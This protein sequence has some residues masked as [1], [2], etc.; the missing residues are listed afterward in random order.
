MVPQQT[1]RDKALAF[2]FRAYTHA[3]SRTDYLRR[4]A[5]GL[6]NVER[7]VGHQSNI[8]IPPQPSTPVTPTP[9]PV[10]NQGTGTR[11]QQSGTQPLQL[12]PNMVNPLNV[13]QL[14]NQIEQQKATGKSPPGL[15]SEDNVHSSSSSVA[16]AP[17]TAHPAKT[18]TVTKSAAVMQMPPRT[19]APFNAPVQS[20]ASE[21]NPELFM[22]FNARNVSQQALQA[23]RT[24]QSQ[25][26]SNDALNAAQGTLPA[27]MVPGDPNRKLSMEQINQI[28]AMGP[29]MQQQ[30]AEPMGTNAASLAH[31]QAQ[32]VRQMQMN[33]AAAGV[34]SSAV[35]ASV[36][37]AQMAYMT[38]SAPALNTQ[39]IYAN[40][41]RLAAQRG[42]RGKQQ[43]QAGAAGSEEFW[44]KLDE[45]KLKYKEPLKKMMPFVQTEI[46]NKH[47]VEKREQFKKH[48]NDC[49]QILNLRRG[50][51]VPATLTTE[52]LEKAC[53][54]IDTVIKLYKDSV[55]KEQTARPTQAGGVE[56]QAGGITGNQYAVRNAPSAHQ[57][58]AATAQQA[59]QV[60][61]AHQEM[62]LRV[63]QQIQHQQNQQQQLQQIQQQ[64][65]QQQLQ[66]R[67]QLQQQQLQQRQQHQQQLL[68][69]QQQLLLQQQRQQAKAAI[70]AAGQQFSEATKAAVKAAATGRITNRAQQ[71]RVRQHPMGLSPAQ[72]ARLAMPIKPEQLQAG[73]DGF[74]TGDMTDE[75]KLMLQR[76]VLMPQQVQQSAQQIQRNFAH[77]AAM[78]RSALDAGMKAQ[79][80][81]APGVA[82]NQAMLKNLQLQKQLQMR[83]AVQTQMSAG[84][85]AEALTSSDILNRR[86]FTRIK[87][88]LS[89]V[90]A[91][92]PIAPT[93]S[94]TKVSIEQNLQHMQ[95][96]VMNVVDQALRWEAF[97][98][99]DSKRGQTERIQ[100]T[101]AALCSMNNASGSGSGELKKRPSSLVD[102]N[103]CAEGD[104]I[105]R[106]KS[107]FECST[108]QGLRLAKRPKNDATDLRCAREAVEADCKAA[109]E[110]NPLLDLEIVEEFEKPVVKCMLLIEEIK[111]PKLVLRVERGY[112]RKGGASYGFERPPLGWVGIVGEIRTRFLKAL[113][114]VPTTSIGVAAYLDAWAREAEAV[115]AAELRCSTSD[116]SSSTDGG[117]AKG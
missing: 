3:E 8:S 87:T 52:L 72:V 30:A 38:Q 96:N 44:N 117:D 6:S 71:S 100:N 106:S 75:Q 42:Q 77:Q 67:Q 11:Q 29:N 80:A 47:R 17:T 19:A 66:Q 41:D 116:L 16:T 34:H 79:Q 20:G 12:M 15:Q 27:G 2:E 110:L 59:Q 69:Q 28:I 85:A 104:D 1:L 70:G 89:S 43:T 58:N 83:N 60:Q 53:K 113:G 54:F 84:L 99:S 5:G 36:T 32:M 91:N 65:N 73:L 107:V 74:P 98:H 94:T 10:A 31:G 25:A 4:I 76:R 48:L 55:V 45:M 112:P 62:F 92:K 114:N 63:R 50:W 56:S 40:F 24:G 68:Q 37:P 105:I 21:V 35:R 46:V 57:Q 14:R 115:V 102:V 95:T 26:M 103:N 109:Q 101:L 7:Q 23:I 51:T 93:I 33:A 78:H 9:V 18:Q 111:L 88:E 97:M 39:D 13:Q 81:L 90:P 64:Q 61:L 49:T 108:E 22:A 82:V 86:N